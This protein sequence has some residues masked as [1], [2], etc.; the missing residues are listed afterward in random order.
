[1]M[2]S[3]AA[4]KR[5]TNKNELIGAHDFAWRSDVDS[6]FSRCEFLYDEKG[7]LTA[8]DFRLPARPLPRN[9]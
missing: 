1:M 8:V 9:S 2:K 7:N 5:R 4:W 6:G 3:A